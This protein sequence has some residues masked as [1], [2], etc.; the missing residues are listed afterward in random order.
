[1]TRLAIPLIFSIIFMTGC[2]STTQSMPKNTNG[3]FSMLT[4]DFNSDIDWI[5]QQ[6]TGKPITTTKKYHVPTTHQRNIL[7][8]IHVTNIN[9]DDLATI[10]IPSQWKIHWGEIDLDPRDTTT[11]ARIF[12]PRNSQEQV[13]IVAQRYFGNAPAELI[14]GVQETENAIFPLKRYIFPLPEHKTALY[15][16]GTGEVVSQIAHSIRPS[17]L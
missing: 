10:D 7:T 12:D 11:D 17:A 8:E 14:Q 2:G 15:I 4:S 9:F 6:Q 5:N 16:S 3:N 1:M 13:T